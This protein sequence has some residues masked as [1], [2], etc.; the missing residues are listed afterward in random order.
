MPHLPIAGGYLVH[1]PDLDLIQ[2][3]LPSITRSCANVAY[4][5]S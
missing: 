1:E 2:I 3:L 4:K 5:A